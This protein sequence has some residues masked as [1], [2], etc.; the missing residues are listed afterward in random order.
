ME[1]GLRNIGDASERICQPG[2]RIDVV[3]LCRHDQRRHDNGPVGATFGAGED[4]GLASEGKT[5]QR[6]FCRVVR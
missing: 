1:L 3:E 2:L 6:P 5:A 4:P